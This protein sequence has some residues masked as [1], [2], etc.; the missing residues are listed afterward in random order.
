MPCNMLPSAFIAA[1]Q[2]ET[3]QILGQ[4]ITVRDDS[5]AQWLPCLLFLVLFTTAHAI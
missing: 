5:V 3:F 4:Q 1:A 2:P